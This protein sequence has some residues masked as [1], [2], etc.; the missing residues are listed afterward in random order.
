MSIPT[1]Y[2]TGNGKADSV[3][4]EETEMSDTPLTDAIVE[5]AGSDGGPRKYVPELLALC[6]NLERQLAERD[7][8]L[9]KAHIEIANLRKEGETK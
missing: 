8:A 2:K 4:A 9:I 3:D 6:R 1:R 5:S 7:V